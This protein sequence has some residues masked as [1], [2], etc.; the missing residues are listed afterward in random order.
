LGAESFL[1][2]M[3]AD[4]A[5]LDARVARAKPEGDARL[6]MSRAAPAEAETHEGA[7]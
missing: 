2:P 1:A 3:R 7:H 5:A 6:A 4:I